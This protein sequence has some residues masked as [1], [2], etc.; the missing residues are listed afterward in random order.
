MK[1]LI[2]TKF[3]LHNCG[4]VTKVPETVKPLFSRGRG[5]GLRD[6]APNQSKLIRGINR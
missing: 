6:Y 1:K 4:Q 5:C 3:F 2:L